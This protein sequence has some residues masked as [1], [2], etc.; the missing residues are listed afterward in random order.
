[1]RDTTQGS[2]KS[3]D[4]YLFTNNSDKQQDRGMKKV[5]FDVVHEWVN[6]CINMF[7]IPRS[8][9]ECEGEYQTIVPN[10]RE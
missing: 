8:K 4:K 1:M 10:E 5:M 9:C 6:E 7:R 3:S 2:F